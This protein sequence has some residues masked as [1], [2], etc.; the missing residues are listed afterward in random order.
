MKTALRSFGPLLFLSVIVLSQACRSGPS[1]QERFSQQVRANL[2]GTWEESKGT[3]ETLE[4]KADGTLLMKSPAENRSC[5]Y[6]FPDSGHIRLDCTR[7][8]GGP[9]FSQTFK[10]SMT[11]DRVMISD[12]ND[13]G[14]Y[15]RMQAPTPDASTQ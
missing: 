4:F 5:E 12:A 1:D 10:F 2:A 3:Q 9:R 14:T 11:S 13:T 6:S 15:K 7:G 8:A